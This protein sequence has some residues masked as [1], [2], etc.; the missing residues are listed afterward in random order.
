MASNHSV[1]AT[2][3]RL[4]S[5][6]KERGVLVFARIDFRGDAANAGLPM[7][8]EQQLIFGNPKAGT[9]LMVA[10]P[11]AALDLPLRV[12]CWQDAQGKTWLAY[13]DPGYLVQRH[14]LPGE[15]TK[16]LSAVIPLIESAAAAE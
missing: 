16:N 4:E 11:V 15:L 7:L 1:S 9:P 5:L 10:N 8:A 2:L 12:I 6:L 13:N 14:A 3:D